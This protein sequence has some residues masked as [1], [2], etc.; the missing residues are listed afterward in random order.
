MIFAQIGSDLG[1][2]PESYVKQAFLNEWANATDDPAALV[3]SLSRVL[4]DA[5]LVVVQ[6]ET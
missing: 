2:L 5:G 1:F 4:S 6:P 3:G